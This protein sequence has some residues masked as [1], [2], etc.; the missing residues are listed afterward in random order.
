M[1]RR[2]LQDEICV[3]ARAVARA[4]RKSKRYPYGSGYCVRDG[5]PVCVFGA[6]L[7]QAGALALPRMQLGS[8]VTNTGALAA[9]LGV[10]IDDISGS[11][12]SCLDSLSWASDNEGDYPDRERRRKTAAAL[13][14]LCD[15][16]KYADL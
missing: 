12:R 13:D 2:G 4:L 3:A 5:A 8:Y 16:L 7:D 14:Y 11:L 10:S 15:A 6:V 9:A 1:S